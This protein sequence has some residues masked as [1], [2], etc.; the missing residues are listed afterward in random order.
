MTLRELAELGPGLAGLL[1]V[2]L[3]IVQI[4]PIKV[5]PWSWIAAKVGGAA[6]KEL[7]DQLTEMKGEITSLKTDLSDLKKQIEVDKVVDSRRNILHFGDELVRDPTKR[8]TKEHFEQ[9]LRDCDRYE[10]YCL[11]HKDFENNQA[12]ITIAR[13]KEIYASCLRDH[14]FL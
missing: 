14:D 2:L 12:V 10:D 13:I 9:I 7:K 11:E 8:H 6:N 1:A 3:T 5:N 4:T